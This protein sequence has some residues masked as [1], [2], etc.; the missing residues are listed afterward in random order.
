MVCNSWSSIE[1]ALC[2]ADVASRPRGAKSQPMQLIQQAGMAM[3]KAKQ[4]GRN[5][6]QWCTSDLN[7][8]VCERMSLR[9]DL[10][11]AIERQ[12][13]NLHYQPQIEARTGRVIG[14]EALLRWEHPEKGYISPA[15]FVPV[16][17]D[18]GQIIPL[19]LWVLDTACAQ[20]RQLGEQGI[21]G[22][23]MAVNISPMHFQRRQFVEYIQTVLSKHGLSAGQLELEITESLLLHNVE[24]AIDTLHR[25]K[26][27]G[28]RI[29]LDDFGTG[30]SSSATSSG[31][32]S[33]RSRLTAC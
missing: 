17:E 24:Q 22:L 18:S 13:F 20:L 4:A 1:Q 10:Q 26:A 8:R 28:V 16:A 14:I 32:P 23:S 7:Q 30:F 31:C 3:Y 11:K 25:L 15:V 12:S 19:S 2:A 29:E 21:T 5:N 27:L 6:F 33:T 9:N